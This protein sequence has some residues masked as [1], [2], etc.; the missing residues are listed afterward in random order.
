MSTDTSIGPE[1]QKGGNENHGN[2]DGRP[3][4]TLGEQDTQQPPATRPAG[5]T[6]G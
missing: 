4:K 2:V 3:A 5:L 1:G 6:T